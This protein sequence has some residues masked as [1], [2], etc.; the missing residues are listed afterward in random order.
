MKDF[1]RLDPNCPPRSVVM[2]DGT[3]NSD[4]QV[5]IKAL[6]TVSVVPSVMGIA[7]GQRV[8]RS[9][10]VSRYTHPLDGGKGPTRSICT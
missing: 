7:S 2:V 8:K 3:P 4:T 1:H 10:Q 6:A 5:W 9:T